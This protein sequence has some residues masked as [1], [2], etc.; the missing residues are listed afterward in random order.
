[1]P[2]ARAVPNLGQPFPTPDLRRPR[3]R[4]YRVRARISASP[5]PPLGAARSALGR[6]RPW[7]APAPVSPARRDPR[8]ATR[9]ISSRRVRG[10][11]PSRP[12]ESSRFEPRLALPAVRPRA[13]P[14]ALRRVDRPQGWRSQPAPAG[15]AGDA[16]NPLQRLSQRRV[17]MAMESRGQA[18]SGIPQVSPESSCRVSH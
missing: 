17:L 4:P 10:F 11:R 18:D 13:L 8:A 12:S 3:G 7:R 14:C 5:V 1:M 2:L 6:A 16:L 9:A 15:A